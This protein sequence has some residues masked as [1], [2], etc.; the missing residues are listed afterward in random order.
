MSGDWKDINEPGNRTSVVTAAQVATGP[1]IPPQQRL[2]TY[3]PDQWEGFVEEWA[4]YCLKKT[5]KHVQRFSGAG[6]MGLDI[7]GFVDDERLQGVW[8]NYQCKHYD[9]ALAPSEVWP[10]FGKIIWHSF[11]GE[12]TTP[13]RYY[14]V[15]PWGAGTKLSRLLANASKLHNEL[16]ENWDKYVKAAITQTQQVP[17]DAALRAY[18]DKFDFSI[19]E[20]K[21]SLQ[22]VDDHRRSPVHA[23]RFGG[24]LPP[25]PTAG[26]PPAEVASGES[27]YVTQLLG[28]YGEHTNTTVTD[29]SAISPQKL[30]DH[31]RRQREA[32]YEAESLR[33]FARD[34][35][36]SGTFESLQ[37][38][39]YIGVIDTHDSV[40]TD[41]Y[42]K[43]C[44]V[45]KAAQEVQI[46]ANALISSANPKD[47]HGICHQLVND[48]RLWWK[49]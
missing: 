44:A 46:T 20:A 15:A 27:H 10:E 39:I 49:K 48:E 8:D 42:H 4:Y 38:D 22:L 23:A 3:S 18:V 5:Y 2:L 6:D 31:F 25:R 28:A 13:R 11:K 24:G 19:F 29:P 40:H 36:P 12:Y 41:G 21:T 45:T 47:R 17:L 16:I 1:V 30:K 7:A 43:V 9:H 26:K 14:F 33:V 32:F 37:N 35:V 34:T